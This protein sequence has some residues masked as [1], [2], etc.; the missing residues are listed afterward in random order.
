[1]IVILTDA[2]VLITCISALAEEGQHQ[3]DVV[4]E[5]RIKGNE[6]GN[7]NVVFFLN[8][9][10]WVTWIIRNRRV[11]LATMPASRLLC[12]RLRSNVRETQSLDE[13]CGRTG[14]KPRRPECLCGLSPV[15]QQAL[16]Q[17]YIQPLDTSPE[18]NW[19]GR[20]EYC[21]SGRQGPAPVL[22]LTGRL[23]PTNN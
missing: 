14:V 3:Y 18:N 10:W 7:M 16:H 22:I 19:D 4:S 12:V 5:Q 6:K 15:R 20:Q 11:V 8:L 2:W 21:Q 13:W 1:M 23:Q 9:S 17:C